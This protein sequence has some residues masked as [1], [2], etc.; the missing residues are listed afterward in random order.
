MDLSLVCVSIIGI[1]CEAHTFVICGCC[2]CTWVTFGVQSIYA[3]QI[4]LCSLF[5]EV[6]N[7]AAFQGLMFRAKN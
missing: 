3:D 4:Y 1:D 2:S 5:F 6:T 7:E